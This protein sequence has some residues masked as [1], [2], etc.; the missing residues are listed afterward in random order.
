MPSGCHLSR[1]TNNQEIAMAALDLTATPY[2]VAPT[3]A[4]RG[5]Q[6]I[7]VGSAEL[8]VPH[9]GVPVEQLPQ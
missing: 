4:A 3:T 5:T 1:T 6:R 9:Y 2:S 8:G 7:V